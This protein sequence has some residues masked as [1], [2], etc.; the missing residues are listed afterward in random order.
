MHIALTESCNHSVRLYH[1]PEHRFLNHEVLCLVLFVLEN[2]S[3]FNSNS[4]HYW[5]L[6]PACIYCIKMKLRAQKLRPT[7]TVNICF[8]ANMSS[9]KSA[10]KTYADLASVTITN[11][12]TSIKHD[13]MKWIYMLTVFCYHVTHE[14]H[15]YQLSYIYIFIKLEF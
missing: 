9:L 7:F 4:P 11:S 13:I 8:Y 2:N 14:L 1:I 10:C 5:P 12:R 6:R 15:I 3:G